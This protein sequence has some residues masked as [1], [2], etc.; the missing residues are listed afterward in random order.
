MHATQDAIATTRRT[1]T[2]RR[3]L[4]Q[5]L[6]LSVCALF[7]SDFGVRGDERAEVEVREPAFKYDG[8]GDQPCL[9]DASRICPSTATLIAAGRP[10]EVPTLPPTGLLILGILI[11]GTTAWTLNKQ[12]Q[13]KKSDEGGSQSGSDGSGKP[14]QATS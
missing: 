1:G 13:K 11:M 9:H 7:A 12:Q 2:R 14:G 3:A 4:S 8:P 6:L 5:L 10:V